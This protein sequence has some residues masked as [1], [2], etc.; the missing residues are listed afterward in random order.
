MVEDDPDTIEIMVEILEESGFHVRQAESAAEAK[1]VDLEEIDL[2]VCDLGL[3]DQSGL[4][5]IRTLQSRRRRPALALSGFGMEADV[6]A[7]HEAGFDEHLAKPVD[8]KV[9][10]ETLRRLALGSA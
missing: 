4:D 10:L 2:I 7:S 8:V 9:L 3:P 5:L 1:R 6:K